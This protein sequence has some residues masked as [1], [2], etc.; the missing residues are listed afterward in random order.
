LN[1]SDPFP[2]KQEIEKVLKECRV[3]RNLNSH[4]DGDPEKPGRNDA[5]L[6]ILVQSARVYLPLINDL[7]GAELNDIYERLAR[8]DDC[9]FYQETVQDEVTTNICFWIS[10]K[11][12]QDFEIIPRN[13][14]KPR[15]CI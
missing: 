12:K 5:E 14:G 8:L 2:K 15:K 1:H 11:R 7:K 6:A 10:L 13:Q 4:S 3:D 9:L